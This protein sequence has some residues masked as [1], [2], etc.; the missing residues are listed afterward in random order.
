MPSFR[1][2]YV[3]TLCSLGD[4]RNKLAPIRPPLGHIVGAMFLDVARPAHAHDAAHVVGVRP[5]A[6]RW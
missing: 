5:L 1:E 6:Q 3:I 4:L 2:N